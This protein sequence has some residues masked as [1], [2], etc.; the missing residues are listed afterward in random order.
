MDQQEQSARYRQDEEW[1]REQILLEPG[2]AA[3]CTTRASR[4]SD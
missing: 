3:R 1:L 4:R 2:W